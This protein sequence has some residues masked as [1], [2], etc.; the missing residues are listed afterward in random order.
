VGDTQDVLDKKLAE[1][2]QLQFDAETNSK[3]YRV[4]RELG[5]KEYYN[6]RSKSQ[7]KSFVSTP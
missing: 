5:S 1:A 2:L 4:N 7:R 6:F 3:M